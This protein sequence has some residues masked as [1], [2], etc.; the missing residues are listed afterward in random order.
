VKLKTII[1]IFAV[2]LLVTP[3]ILL[4]H[5]YRDSNYSKIQC[6]GT[7]NY[8]VLTRENTSGIL[9]S[10]RLR[11]EKEFS[12]GGDGVRVGDGFVNTVLPYKNINTLSFGKANSDYRIMVYKKGGGS[13]NF[14]LYP[15]YCFLGL[16]A[17]MAKS[18]PDVLVNLK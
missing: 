7:E 13:L 10:L 14:G 18:N 4:T 2:L 11:S 5:E 16:S 1:I 15:S 9:S 12:F 3:A 8:Y 6:N 17:F